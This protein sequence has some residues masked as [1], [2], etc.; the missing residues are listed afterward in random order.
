MSLITV[1]RNGI[2]V[3][4]NNQQKTIDND[5]YKCVLVLANKWSG[6][7]A[8]LE[9]DKYI[10][11]DKLTENLSYGNGYI[12]I[13]GNIYNRDATIKVHLYN[14]IQISDG[15]IFYASLN[16][17][18][19]TI[20]E[21]GQNLQVVGNID[22]QTYKGIPCGY[23]NGESG[24]YMNS[25]DNNLPINYSDR[26][27]CG[28]MYAL[29]N[30]FK[31]ILS[32]GH[33]GPSH[34]GGQILGISNSSTPAYCQ[35]PDILDGSINALNKWLYICGVCKNGIRKLYV[36]GELKNQGSMTQATN[37]LYGIH[38]GSS[39]GVEYL[40]G[41]ISSVRI[42]NRALEDSQINYLSKEFLGKW[43]C[44]RFTSET[45]QDN[46]W[47]IS[48]GSQYESPR[49]A[50]FKAF[51]GDF[52]YESNKGWFGATNNQNQWLLIRNKNKAVNIKK[53][54]FACN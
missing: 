27:V 36:N 25:F 34:N 45:R 13:I 48:C 43:L 11:E 40:N 46:Y 24:L 28:W 44:P 38:I 17:Q 35:Q 1:Y 3:T 12:P 19:H 37:N 31:W 4:I 16:G 54:I 2:Y 9:N 6:Y 21:T 30:G 47:Q 39:C 42:Y 26:T 52:S 32:W 29:E 22:Y 5:Y 41:Y 8:I 23:F 20:A 18:N 15:L 33:Q 51:N 53:N 10:F 49:W 50:C 7:K 14:N